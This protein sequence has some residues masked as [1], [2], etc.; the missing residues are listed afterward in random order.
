MLREEDLLGRDAALDLKS[1]ELHG[2]SEL[3]EGADLLEIIADALDAPLIR[4]SDSVIVDVYE[5]VDK[6]ELLEGSFA[7]TIECLLEKPDLAVI[8]AKASGLTDV[9][10]DVVRNWCREEGRVKVMHL[11]L[12]SLKSSDS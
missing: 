11:V 1:K 3:F 6:I 12:E 9:D 4:C 2:L 7:K 10:L 8:S 5:G